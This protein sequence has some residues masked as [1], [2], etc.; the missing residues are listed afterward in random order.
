MS[1]RVDK[2]FL[3]FSSS[4]TVFVVVGVVIVDIGVRVRVIGVTVSVSRIFVIFFSL[5]SLFFQQLTLISVVSWFRT[6]K[7]RWFG[8]VSICVFIIVAQSV[9]L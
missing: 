9:Y 5:L 6:V 4:V 3:A 7:A 8:F 1:H 2:Q